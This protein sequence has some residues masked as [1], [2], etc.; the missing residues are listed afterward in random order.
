MDFHQSFAI[1]F[2][3]SLRGRKRRV[4]QQFLN[5]P[6]ISATRQQVRGKAVP[7]RMGGCCIGESEYGADI[8]HFSLRDGG[9]QAFAPRADEQRTILIQIVGAHFDIIVDRFGDGF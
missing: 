8:A 7:K 5:G 1:D 6:K 2:G 3:I 9:V 4:A